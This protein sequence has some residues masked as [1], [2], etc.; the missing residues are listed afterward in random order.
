MT[1]C[2]PLEEVTPE[3]PEYLK[4]LRSWSPKMGRLSPESE[5]VSCLHL[6]NV[7]RTENIHQT[8]NGS[9]VG[10]PKGDTGFETRAEEQ[11]EPICS[12]E[13]SGGNGGCRGCYADDGLA[14]QGMKSH[15]AEPVSAAG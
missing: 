12:R 14:V 15:W 5:R 8:E 11:Q 13:E 6:G 3:S 1:T 7:P 9:L 10:D 2:H 4:R